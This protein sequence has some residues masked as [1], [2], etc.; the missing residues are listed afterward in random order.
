MV[1]RKFAG[2]AMAVAALMALAS[3][4]VAE[5]ARSLKDF[6]LAERIAQKVKSG[7]PLEIYVSYHDV[8]RVRAPDQGGGRARR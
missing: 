5:E 2:L 6:P 7:E 8:E 4:A 1:F 3:G